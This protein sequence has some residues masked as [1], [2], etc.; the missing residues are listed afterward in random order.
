MCVL[1][2]GLL[3]VIPWTMEFYQAPL[4]MG[5]FRQEQEWARITEE[6]YKKY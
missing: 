3:F 4:F 1:C 2:C 6:L 5:F